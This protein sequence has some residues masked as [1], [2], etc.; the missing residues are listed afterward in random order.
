MFKHRA[1]MSSLAKIVPKMEELQRALKNELD[2]WS[3]T[4]GKMAKKIAALLV[5]IDTLANLAGGGNFKAFVFFF[6]T[7]AVTMYRLRKC[8]LGKRPHTL[9]TRRARNAAV[10]AMREVCGLVLEGLSAEAPTCARVSHV[11]G[12]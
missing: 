3:G 6:Q 2:R 11:D 7:K 4:G 12:K 10:R 8:F 9:Q 1:A 5:D